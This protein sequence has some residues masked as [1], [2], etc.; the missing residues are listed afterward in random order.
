MPIS[1]EVAG[2]A[3][4]CAARIVA[5]LE[6]GFYDTIADAEVFR[7][8]RSLVARTLVAPAFPT[9]LPVH[10]RRLD[11]SVPSAHVLYPAPFDAD[12]E[13]TLDRA[14]R[15]LGG[16]VRRALAALGP[17]AVVVLDAKPFRWVDDDDLGPRRDELVDGYTFV[18]DLR[19]AVGVPGPTRADREHVGAV[20]GAEIDRRHAEAS[21]AF[22]RVLNAKIDGASAE[23]VNEIAKSIAA[24]APGGFDGIDR[25]VERPR[26]ARWVDYIDRA[27]DL[28]TDDRSPDGSAAEAAA[29]RAVAAASRLLAIAS[30]GDIVH[31]GPGHELVDVRRDDEDVI[32]ACECGADARIDPLAIRHALP[33]VAADAFRAALAGEIRLALPEPRGLG[34]ESF[35]AMLKDVYAPEAVRSLAYREA[36]F[37]DAMLR[38][39]EVIATCPGWNGVA[40]LGPP[41]AAR[42]DELAVQGGRYL[43]DDPPSGERRTSE[44]WSF[45]VSMRLE[46]RERRRA[47][48]AA[49]RLGWDPEGAWEVG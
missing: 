19:F 15:E 24:N 23:P 29:V 30:D 18:V 14:G 4:D 20:V 11:V 41:G 9:P 43:A 21:R 27:S 10:R 6:R 37:A 7:G 34:L 22:S 46:E 8:V 39:G 40:D 32:L 36:P 17:G 38:R 45:V 12:L 13:R 42:P 26:G 47:A 31:A 2:L 3:R 5:T 1:P 48:D 35:D 33:R 44:N 28:T 16:Y 25:G 49:A